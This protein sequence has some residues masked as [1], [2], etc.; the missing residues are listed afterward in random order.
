MA[1]EPHGACA[2][3]RDTVRVAI[4]VVVVSLP[5]F[6]TIVVG[7]R[8]ASFGRGSGGRSGGRRSGGCV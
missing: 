6:I 2:H 7:F 8:G 4:I 3:D 5:S 1:G